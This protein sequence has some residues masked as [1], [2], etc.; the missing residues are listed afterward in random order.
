MADITDTNTNADGVITKKKGKPRHISEQKPENKLKRINKYT[1]CILNPKTN[2]PHCVMVDRDDTT[3]LLAKM[4][5]LWKLP[6]CTTE[7]EYIERAE[8]FFFEYC[9]NL[10]IKP[11]IEGLCLAYDVH[12]DTWNGWEHGER[13]KFWSDLVLKCKNAVQFYLTTATMDGKLNPN[14][15]QFYG[16]NYFGMVDKKEITLAPGNAEGDVD[17]DAIRQRMNGIEGD[18]IEGKVVETPEGNG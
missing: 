10:G 16:R 13:G 8:W 7:Q 5:I 4:Q 1:E 14:V 9:Q 2:L 18:V 6:K 15:W 3:E 17:L 12:K 11:T